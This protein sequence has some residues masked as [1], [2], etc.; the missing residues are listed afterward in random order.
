MA[1]SA[2]VWFAIVYLAQHYVVDALLGLA[3]VV[4][5]CAV[6]SHPAFTAILRP[7]AAVRLPIPVSPDGGEPD[8][9]GRPAGD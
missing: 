1:W 9:R 3:Y 5:I 4:V 6:T 8:G 7:L 2:L